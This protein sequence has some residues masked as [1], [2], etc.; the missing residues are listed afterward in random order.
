MPLLIHKYGAVALA[1]TLAENDIFIDACGSA[2]NSQPEISA[3]R[4]DASGQNQ[5]A[6]IQKNTR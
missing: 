2:R 5:S 4:E 1:K 6:P 3:D